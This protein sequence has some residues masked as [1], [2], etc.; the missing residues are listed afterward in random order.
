MDIKREDLN[1]A[2]II[3]WKKQKS[4]NPSPKIVNII[5][6]WLRVDSAITFFK[7]LSKIPHTLD[8]NI[9]IIPLEKIKYRLLSFKR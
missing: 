6:N 3:I 8:T 1:K 5:P 2:C 7:S 9:V 4:L